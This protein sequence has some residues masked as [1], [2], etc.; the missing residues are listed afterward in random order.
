MNIQVYRHFGRLGSYY[1]S[2]MFV[3]E[4]AN[5]LYLLYCTRHNVPEVHQYSRY[6]PKSSKKKKTPLLEII[7]IPITHFTEIKEC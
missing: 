4:V 7:Y 3:Q 2:I 6:K 1:E 5:Y